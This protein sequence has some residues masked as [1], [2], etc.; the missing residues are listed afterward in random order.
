MFK[1]VNPEVKAEILTKVKSGEKVAAVAAQYGVSEKTIYTWLSRKAM[2]TISLL[3][4]NRLKNENSQLKQIIGVLTFELEK[5]KKRREILALIQSKVKSLGHT[6]LCR[7]LKI[8]RSTTYKTN[9]QARIRQDELLR[10]QILST[11]A[12][13]PAYGHRRIALALSLGKKRVRR[14]E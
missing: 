1:P 9:S 7:L 10:E 11:L 3:E 6:F 8:S 5:S 4:Y 2:G 13:N 14:V 12:L